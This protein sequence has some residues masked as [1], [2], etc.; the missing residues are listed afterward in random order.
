MAD[1]ARLAAS[2][3]GS[4]LHQILDRRPDHDGSG[5]IRIRPS[6]GDGRYELGLVAPQEKLPPCRLASLARPHSRRSMTDLF[7]VEK[8][9]YGPPLP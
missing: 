6:V 7:A 8:R 2:Q 3:C 9:V 1:R 4:R 5:C